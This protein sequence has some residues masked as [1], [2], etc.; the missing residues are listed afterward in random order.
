[1]MKHSLFI[2]LFS[3]S[4]AFSLLIFSQ[5]VIGSGD[6]VAV[7]CM[8]FDA[9]DPVAGYDFCDACLRA[10]PRSSM[11][12]LTELG[13]ISMELIITNAT[14]VDSSIKHL[15]NDPGLSQKTKEE[16]QNCLSLYSKSITTVKQAINYLKSDELNSA[17]KMISASMEAPKACERGISEGS[18]LTTESQTLYRLNEIAFVI[19]TPVTN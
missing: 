19:T 14:N 9:K 1:M 13:I 12:N 15:L 18:P 2:Y 11:A 16:L 3:L 6:L 8:N 10:D 7:I 17:N 5:T 4:L